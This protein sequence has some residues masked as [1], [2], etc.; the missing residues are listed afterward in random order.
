LPSRPE[1]GDLGKGA[2]NEIKPTTIMVPMKPTTH[3]R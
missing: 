1:Y 2:N 3:G